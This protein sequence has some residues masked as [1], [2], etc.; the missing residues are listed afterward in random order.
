MNEI[1]GVLALQGG[2]ASHI[3]V[4]RS[5][6]ADAREIR[7][8]RELAA[9]DALVIPGGESTVLTKLLM[10]P[11]TGPGTG[12]PWERSPLFEAVRAF[13][14]ERPAMGTCAGLIM[15]ARPC[16]DARVVPLDVLPVTVARNAYGRQTESFV[17]RISL[18]PAFGGAG[19]RYPATFIRA[20][21]IVAMDGEV[22]VLT[23]SRARSGGGEGEP[24]MARWRNLLGLTFHP[25]LTPSD[26]RIHGYFLAMVREGK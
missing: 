5:L 19:E 20:P 14:L 8:E 16:G 26:P 23:R 9:C 10:R 7:T 3:A 4:L 22:T 24:V 1:V 11:G 6:G 25:E 15:L 21:R 13:A 12:A 2:Y 17:E 18:D